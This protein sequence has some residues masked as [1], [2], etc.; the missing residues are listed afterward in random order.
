MWVRRRV[1]VAAAMRSFPS[2]SALLCLSLVLAFASGCRRSRSAAAVHDPD[3]S[4]ERVIAQGRVVGYAE[5]E[6]A[7]AWTGIP[8]AEP[9]VGPLRWRAPA[10]KQPWADTFRAVRFGQIGG[11][12]ARTPVT[13]AC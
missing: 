1:M 6:G 2:R 11:G 7:H 5:Q 13:W 3:P 4:S 10:P 9:P 8:F 12:H